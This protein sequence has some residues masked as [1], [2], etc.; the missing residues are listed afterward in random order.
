MTD[1]DMAATAVPAIQDAYPDAFAHCYGCG[2]LNPQGHQLKSRLLGDEV[3]AEFTAPQQ[4]TGGFPGKAYGGLVASLLD[5][6][7]TASAAGFA[8][9][10]DGIEVAA[11]RPL[12][13]FVTATLKVDFKSPTP[14]GTPLV[15]RG[16]L[17]SLEGRKAWIEMTLSA[18]E[19][20]C[21][22]GEMLAIRLPD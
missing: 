5:C 11:G 12:S 3:I 13:R 2:R 22:T 7:G 15:I 17:K 4:Y 14:L 6:H 18:G 9:R 20:V 1:S 21:A 16:K 10:A 8:A 19:T